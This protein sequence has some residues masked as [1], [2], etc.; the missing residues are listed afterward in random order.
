MLK[1]TTGRQKHRQ[2]LADD[3]LQQLTSLVENEDSSTADYRRAAE[4][5]VKLRETFSHKDLPDWTGRSLEYRDMIER[6]YRQAEIPADS[7]SPSTQSKLRYH[8]GNVVRET[9]PEEH[10]EALGLEKKGPAGRAVGRPRSRRPAELRKTRADNPL[11]LS[12]LA[13]DSIRLLQVVEYT[14]GDRE[15]VEQV[16]RQ[17]VDECM[18]FLSKPHNN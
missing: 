16:V 13:L 2:Q 11:I 12:A 3:V 17:I 18:N 1:M 9:A 5:I 7:G 4:A 8:I 10:L 15:V 6:L 14:D